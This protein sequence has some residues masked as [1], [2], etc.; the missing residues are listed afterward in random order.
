MVGQ[1]GA[2]GWEPAAV[3]TKA[4]VD[5]ANRVGLPMASQAAVDK[6]NKFYGCTLTREQVRLAPFCVEGAPPEKQ[7]FWR[8][9]DE[10][11][12]CAL[13][14]GST[15]HGGGPHPHL[16]AGDFLYDGIQ[17][18]WTNNGKPATFA[19]GTMMRKD[20]F[21]QSHRGTSRNFCIF[22]APEKAVAY[23]QGEADALHQNKRNIGENCAYYV[24]GCLAQEGQ[25]NPK[26]SPF[27]KMNATGWPMGAVEQGMKLG[28][29]MVLQ[30][31]PQEDFQRAV[32]SP[33]H[34]VKF[35]PEQM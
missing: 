30:V 8:F 7:I 11:K 22:K 29:D 6:L 14:V 33:N 32:Q 28:P 31:L 17:P 25:K 21:G 5:L 26:N 4:M 13:G 9:V 12:K 16:L 34:L 1:A 24:T 15:P 35:W 18:G 3:R 19:D 20:T 10:A 27:A 2:A 23:V